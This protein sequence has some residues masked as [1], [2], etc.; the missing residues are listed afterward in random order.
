M[1]LLT[2]LFKF[3]LVFFLAF[4]FGLERQKSHKPIGFGTFIFVSMG[5]CG[6]AITALVLHT[7]N[8]LPLLGAIISGIGFLGAGA[9]IKTTDKIFG[10]T[11]A[12]SIWLFSI[13]GLVI[14]VGEYMLALIM[15]GSIWI[16]LLGDNYLEHRGIG[17][18]QKKA[19]LTAHMSLKTDQLHDLLGT[20]KFTVVSM[21]VNQKDKII[22]LHLVIEETKQVM[23]QIPKKLFKHTDII[24]FKLE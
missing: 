3:S 18:Y 7:E 17:S 8:P 13:I 4:V 11:S 23:N 15:Y 14:G 12:A 6:L 10:F 20:T 21:E 19:M 9:L 1:D 22:I 16:V 2:I 24:S 5:S